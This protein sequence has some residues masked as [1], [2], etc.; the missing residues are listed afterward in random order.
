MGLI[1]NIVNPVSVNKTRVSLSLTCGKKTIMTR[2]PAATWI[3]W[4]RKMRRLLKVYKE[5][6]YP[7][8][9]IMEIFG[10]ER[11]G[12]SSFSPVDCRKA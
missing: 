5:E 10:N 6:L 12:H 7:G 1:V 2:A 3:K 9:I 8:F 4:S 11:N